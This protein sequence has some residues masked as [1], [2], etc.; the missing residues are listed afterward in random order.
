[1]SEGTGRP[2]DVGYTLW[3]ALAALVV[4]VVLAV[5]GAGVPAFVTAVLTLYWGVTGLLRLRRIH[6]YVQSRR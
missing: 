3:F 4:T 2:R 6:L 5:A 1:M